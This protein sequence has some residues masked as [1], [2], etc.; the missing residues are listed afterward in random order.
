MSS[1][2]KILRASVIASGA[3]AMDCSCC[4]ITCALKLNFFPHTASQA[5]AIKEEFFRFSRFCLS[6]K[7]LTPTTSLFPKTS[8]RRTDL[9][10]LDSGLLIS[11]I[12]ATTFGQNF[13]TSSRLITGK[14]GSVTASGCVTDSITGGLTSTLGWIGATGDDTLSADGYLI[15]AADV[16]ALRS[17]ASIDESNKGIC[18]P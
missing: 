6:N 1:P 12:L 15:G 7:N 3:V 18:G 11:R 9:S 17:E 14:V 8:I 10:I 4:L 13:S 2:P 16:G 5:S